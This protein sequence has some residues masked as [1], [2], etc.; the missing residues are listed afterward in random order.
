[1]LPYM[2]GQTCQRTVRA[3]GDYAEFFS[4]SGYARCFGP[5]TGMV[6]GDVSG[7]R[8][9]WCHPGSAEGLRWQPLG[10][11]KKPGSGTEPIHQE[12]MM[13]SRFRGS[14][15]SDVKSAVHPEPGFSIPPS[16]CSAA[17]CAPRVTPKNPASG[18]IPE[19][20]PRPRPKATGIPRPGE[21]SKNPARSVLSRI[22]PGASGQ[23][24]SLS[25]FGAAIRKQHLKHSNASKYLNPKAHETKIIPV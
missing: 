2:P 4:G 21:E 19:Y 7:G 16:G 14:C 1:M 11:I 13:C 3:L 22:C 10:G 6:F 18:N 25:S 8:V 24:S 15:P 17:L 9:L 12:H 23:A 5:G 20:H